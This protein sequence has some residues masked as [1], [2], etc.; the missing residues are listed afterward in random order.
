MFD[1][2]KINKGRD[3]IQEK[4]GDDNILEVFGGWD[5]ITVESVPLKN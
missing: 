3:E 5:S 4:G 2:L 1:Y